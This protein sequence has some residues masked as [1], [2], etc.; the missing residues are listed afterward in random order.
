[1]FDNKYDGYAL[2]TYVGFAIFI[3]GLA[4]YYGRVW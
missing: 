4:I 1:M 2:A 3:A